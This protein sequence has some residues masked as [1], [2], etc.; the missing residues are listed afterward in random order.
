MDPI[1]DVLG[2]GLPALLALAGAGASIGYAMTSS[3]SSGFLVAKV[4]FALAA[5]DVV[6]FAIYWV[7]ATRQNLPWNLVVP[8]IAA[9][10]A[11]PVLVICLQWLGNLEIQL[12]TRLFPSNLPTPRMPDVPQIPGS[13]SGSK[14]M[15][16]KC[17][18]SHFMVTPLTVATEGANERTVNSCVMRDPL[19]SL[20]WC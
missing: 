14:R 18:L 20:L 15:S 2:I 17:L 11:V 7:V 5:F 9:V 10:L 13:E 16:T 4:C 8:T 12:S 1:T 19:R 6:A 3:E